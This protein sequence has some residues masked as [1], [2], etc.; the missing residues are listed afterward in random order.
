MDKFGDC[1]VKRVI[2]K[3]AHDLLLHL[4]SVGDITKQE[5]GV[6]DDLAVITFYRFTHCTKLPQAPLPMFLFGTVE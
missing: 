2:L 5:K 6:Y 1:G 4:E 3:S